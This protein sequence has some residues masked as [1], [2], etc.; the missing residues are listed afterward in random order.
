MLSQIFGG[1]L[2][3]F[4]LHHFFERGGIPANFA[5]KAS[6]RIYGRTGATLEGGVDLRMGIGMDI[7]TNGGITIIHP[8][9]HADTHSKIHCTT[10][11][12]TSADF[13][14]HFH[15]AFGMVRRSSLADERS[16]LAFQ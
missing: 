15:P 3:R 6:L 2:N 10:R 12:A 14:G 8:D 16:S 11:F 1:S 9:I 5:F 13:H 4:R 7:R